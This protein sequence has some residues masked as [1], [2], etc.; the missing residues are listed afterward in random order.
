M[1]LKSGAPSTTDNAPEPMEHRLW[2]DGEP[3]LGGKP[4]RTQFSGTASGELPSED[5]EDRRSGVLLHATPSCDVWLLKWPPGTRVGPHDHGES[6]GVFAVIKGT[7]TELRWNGPIPEQRTVRAGEAVL[8]DRGVIHDVLAGNCTSYSIH[9]YSPP[10]T[11]MSFYTPTP[12]GNGEYDRADEL[13]SPEGIRRPPDGS[14][15]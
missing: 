15:Q 8:V 13:P 9:V 3:T 5:P 10:L 14:S 12:S 7:L 1:T 11:T 4:D 6:V 2:R